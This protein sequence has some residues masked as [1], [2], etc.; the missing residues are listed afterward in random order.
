[1]S[2]QV[3]EVDEVMVFCLIV[4][5]QVFCFCFCLLLLWFLSLLLPFLICGLS[6]LFIFDFCFL[7]FLI[8][9]ICFQCCL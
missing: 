1:M 4:S 6:V 5:F 9:D 2:C 7:C 8:F 3:V